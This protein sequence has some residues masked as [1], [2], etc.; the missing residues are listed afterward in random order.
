MGAGLSF[1]CFLCGSSAT[2]SS[3]GVVSTVLHCSSCFPLARCTSTSTRKK[4]EERLIAKPTTRSSGKRCGSACPPCQEAKAIETRE[5]SD[6]E[7][8]QRTSG[9]GSRTTRRRNDADD[10]LFCARD[11]A[12]GRPHVGGGRDAA[13]GGGRAGRGREGERK[14]E[15]KK[16]MPFFFRPLPRVGLSK[17][18]RTREQAREAVSPSL[19]LSLSLSPTTHTAHSTHHPPP[20]SPE[21]PPPPPHLNLQD[22]AEHPDRCRRLP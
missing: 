6:L 20:S 11:G 13:G 3:V 19:S 10:W 17:E 2:P 18:E 22:L 8:K 15:K 9:K 21:S 14:R 4:T 1:P 7:K 16:G 5:G 12:S